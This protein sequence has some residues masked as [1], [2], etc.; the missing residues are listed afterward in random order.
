MM[1]EDLPWETIPLVVAEIQLRE[2]THR[3]KL[4]PPASHVY[5]WN[6]TMKILYHLR[7][8]ITKSDMFRKIYNQKY[9][10]VRKRYV[11]GC[12]HFR[13]PMPETGYE[14]IFRATS[15][16]KTVVLNYGGQFY[17][18]RKLND[19]CSA[20]VFPLTLHSHRSMAYLRIK[21]ENVHCTTNE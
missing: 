13:A 6:F 7:W 20:L 3:V 19:E 11:T 1:Q 10:N 9:Y 15:L 17:P 21:Y 16:I 8:A 5:I 2:S 12:K 4:P 18:V 14:A